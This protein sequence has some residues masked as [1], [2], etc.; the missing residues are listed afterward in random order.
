MWGSFTDADLAAVRSYFATRPPLEAIDLE[1]GPPPTDSIFWYCQQMSLRLQS[2][3]CGLLEVSIPGRS[4][5]AQLWKCPIRE[6]TELPHIT[7][8]HRTVGDFLNSEDIIAE[9]QSMAP[10]D[11]V[12]YQ[13]LMSAC[14][15]MM[16]ISASSQADD[17]LEDHAVE[18]L[19]FYQWCPLQS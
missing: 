16:K 4:G 3:S 15:S 12:A 17:I 1:I 13:N 5:S 7:Y 11:F 6:R 8:L 18:L 9:M 2:R 14:L 10:P 19:R